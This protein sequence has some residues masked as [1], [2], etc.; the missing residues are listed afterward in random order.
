MSDPITVI[1]DIHADP[2]RLE[3]SLSAAGNDHIAFLGDFIDG[4]TVSGSDDAAVL[5]KAFALLDSGRASAVMG[6]HELN[7]ILFHTSGPD[8]QP[9]RPHEPKNLN[10]HATFLDRFD[11]KP[12]EIRT[13]RDRILSLPLWLDLGGIRLVHACWD[14][15]AIATI[16]KRRPD[17]RL[18][19]EDLPEVSAKT[20]AFAMAVEQL[21]S[22]PEVRLPKGYSFRDGKGVERHHVRLAWWRA[23]GGTWREVSLSVPDPDELP[24]THVEGV[25]GVPRYAS[26]E[27]PVFVGHY[28]MTGDPRIEAPHAACLDY[29]ETPCVYRW[30][31]EDQL[32]QQ[33][34]DVL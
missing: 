25:E 1:P 11:G 22:G 14:T 2:Q 19:P 3:A 31:G 8:G 9:L 5:D 23:D 20:T 32:A 4:K 27:A 15:G 29:P 33:N 26:T 28:K 30:R 13:W 10:Q 6:N 18:L 12:D 7:A 21:T 34:L 16:S 17:G 24:R